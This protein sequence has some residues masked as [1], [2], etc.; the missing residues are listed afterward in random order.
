MLIVQVYKLF[1]QPPKVRDNIAVRYQVAQCV[2][3][4]CVRR[5]P[6]ALQVA[7]QPATAQVPACEVQALYHQ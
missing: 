3:Q 5:H 4:D 6:S 2:A 7:R 1:L